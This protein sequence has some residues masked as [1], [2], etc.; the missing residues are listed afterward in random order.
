MSSLTFQVPDEKAE[1]LT[2][3]ARERGI[4]VEELLQRI[5]DDFLNR[6]GSFE[7][8]AGYVLA[9]NAELYRRLAK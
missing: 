6:R 7:S 4:P 2:E 9:K 8:A 3:A 5:A 1:Q